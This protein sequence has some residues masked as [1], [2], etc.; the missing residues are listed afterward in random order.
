M[1]SPQGER[2]D[3]DVEMSDA[4][5]LATTPDPLPSDDAPAG[6]PSFRDKVAWCNAEKGSDVEIPLLP[7]PT[8]V[9]THKIDVKVLPSTEAQVGAD[10]L[11][12]PS[13]SSTTPVPT[14]GTE[15]ATESMPP[16]PGRRG[17]VLALR[18]PSAIPV[19]PPKG[20]KRRFT[21]GHNGESSQQCANFVSLIDELISECGSEADRLSKE[22]S[23][24]QE[25]SSQ[26]EAKL[27]DIKDTHSA[28]VSWLEAQIGGLERDLGKTASS[29]LKEKQ[30]R[31][32]KSSEIC[33]LQKKI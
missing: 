16:P 17:I 11:A 5:P 3:C 19:A 29:Q 8:V 9:P 7:A 4:A 22:L 10:A 15:Q 24:S 32:A 20:W 6:F 25:K 26:L 18:A 14:Y 31:K 28:E 2:K 1:P 23:E 33:R 13:G 27:A 12:Q 21:R 30:A